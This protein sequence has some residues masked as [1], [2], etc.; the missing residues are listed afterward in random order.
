[1]HYWFKSYSDLAELFD[2]A[3]WG[4]YIG[5]GLGLQPACLYILTSL[6]AIYGYFRYQR[7]YSHMLKDLVLC[8][9][10][11]EDSSI[12]HTPGLTTRLTLAC[13]AM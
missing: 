12:L 13:T 11:I 4:S 8:G 7:Y 6:N 2:F 3:S 10:L 9:I 1:M 5:K